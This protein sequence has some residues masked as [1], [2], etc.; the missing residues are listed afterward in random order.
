MVEPW[1]SAGKTCNNHGW[2]EGGACLCDPG[3]AG[4]AC[5]TCDGVW[6]PAPG[7]SPLLCQPS[8]LINGTSG[9]DTLDGTAE[10]DMLRGLEG[11]DTLR[12]LDGNDYLN[13]N[14]GNDTL[15]GN[16]GRDEVRGGSDDDLVQG[17]SGD[18]LVS[19][20]VGNDHVVGGGGNDRLMGGEGND[21]LEG[22]EGDDRYVLD[23]L[24]NDTLDDISGADAARCVPGVR[25]VSNT[26][27]DGN[28]LLRFNTGGT[29]LILG[30][31]VE[32]VLGCD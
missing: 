18:D 31:R 29:A 2:C 13:G 7:L 11:V 15:N 8:R 6:L 32:Q 9:N 22:G 1:Q 3:Y 26:L 19:G 27:V 24:G 17:G 20:D 21:R 16:A 28:R 23:G 30:D 14:Q 4:N 12:G 5:S 25:V 10:G